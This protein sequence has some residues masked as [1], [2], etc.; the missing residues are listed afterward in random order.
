MNYLRLFTLTGFY[1]YYLY[2]IKEKIKINF[3]FKKIII[4][5]NDDFD[6]KSINYFKSI[7][8]NLKIDNKNMNFNNI[9]IITENEKLKNIQY[10]DELKRKKEEQKRIEKERR[11]EEE[12]RERK[13]REKYKPFENYT[14]L[15]TIGNKS[16][17]SKVYLNEK[18]KDK[19]KKIIVVGFLEDNP[20]SI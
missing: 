9:H 6:L 18:E 16:N 20:P 4:F 14:C 17:L 19:N 2:K 10:N 1:Y 12:E 7:G 3:K 5:E 15:Y 13:K 8:L 11:R